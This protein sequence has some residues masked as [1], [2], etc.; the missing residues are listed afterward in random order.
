M[1]DRMAGWDECLKKYKNEIAAVTDILADEK[2]K[3]TYKI[4]TD[5]RSLASRERIRCFEQAFLLAI[6]NKGYEG[7]ALHNDSEQVAKKEIIFR[8]GVQNGMLKIH[9]EDA[10][11]PGRLIYGRKNMYFAD[12]FFTFDK[13]CVFLDVGAYDGDTVGEIYKA[14]G[15]TFKHIFSIEPDPVNYQ[16]LV[17]NMQ[18]LIEAGRLTTFNFALGDRD[19][20]VGFCSHDVAS[21]ISPDGEIT[22]NMKDA[23]TFIENLTPVPMF[24]K[25]DIENNDVPTL[26]S[27]SR[28]IEHYRPAMALS[29]YHELTDLFKIPLMVNRMMPNAKLFIRHNTNDFSETVLY[30]VPDRRTD[31]QKC[32]SGKF[33]NR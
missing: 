21:R 14:T 4:L 16:L 31:L 1:F 33:T 11:E 23:G 2:S 28:F 5:S 32:Q 25:M 19:A 18:P 22:V 7:A 13:E 9:R 17:S 20:E 8:D 29:I 12:N 3:T 27:M 15:N 26:T 10:E 6:G 24:I 30:V